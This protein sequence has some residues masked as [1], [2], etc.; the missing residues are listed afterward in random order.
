MLVLICSSMTHCI[1]LFDNMNSFFK[2]KQFFFYDILATQVQAELGK[3]SL[4]QPAKGKVSIHVDFSST[5]RLHVLLLFFL[6][7]F[8]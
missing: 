5:L 2:S 3:P 8:K 7:I 6:L 1:L 4:L